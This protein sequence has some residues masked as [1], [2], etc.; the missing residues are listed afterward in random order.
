MNIETGTL[1]G[2]TFSPPGKV[3][4]PTYD[5]VGPVERCDMRDYIYSRISLAPGT[6]RFNEY[7]GKHPEKKA[8]DEDM[9]RRA[10]KS[11]A[12]NGW[13]EIP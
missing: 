12:E 6:D 5:I 13:P 1:K 10:D 9:G 3:E 8:V 11:V 2:L 7:Y 4:R